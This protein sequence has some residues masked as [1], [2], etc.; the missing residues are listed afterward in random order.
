MTIEQLQKL[1]PPAT[2]ETWHQHINSG[3]TPGGWVV[4]SAV[5]A[6]S[7]F[8]SV[9]AV[10]PGARTTV[11][12]WAKVGARATIGEGAKVGA[13]ATVGEGATWNISPLC[14]VGT[15]HLVCIPSSGVIQ[16]GCMARPVEWWEEH[17]KAAGRDQSYPSAQLSEYA[18]YIALAKRWMEINGCAA[19]DK[20]NAR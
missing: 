19:E 1:F 2:P 17:Y 16:I 4:N 12:E 6:P 11:G 8:I 15:R 9:N 5:I 18:E 14:I 13:R 7:A 20:A 3:G 10:V